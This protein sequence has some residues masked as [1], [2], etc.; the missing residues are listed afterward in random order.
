MSKRSA[1]IRADADEVATPGGGRD[2]DVSLRREIAALRESQLAWAARPVSAR[3]KI[4]REIRR[5]IA[6]DPETLAATVRLPQRASAAET[7]AAE[8]LPLA[9]ACRFLEREAAKAL[10]PRQLGRRGRALWLGRV[11]LRVLREPFGVVLVIAPWNY[12]LFLPGVQVLQALVA[13]NAVLLKPAPGASEPASAFARLCHSAGIDAGLFRVLPEPPEMARAAIA[14][15]VDKVILTGS[16]ATGQTVLAELAARL[17]PATMELSGCDAVFVRADADVELVAKALAFGLRLNG[18]ATCIAPRRVFV[19]R[20]LFD[21]LQQRLARLAAQMPAVPVAPET[22][23]RVRSLVGEALEA[24]AG[25]VAG[26]LNGPND[27]TPLVV[28]NAAPAMELLK[29]DVFAPVVSLVPVDSDEE[30]LAAAAQC[31]YALGAAVFGEA[32]GAAALAEKVDAGCVV[33]NDVIVPTADPRLPFGGRRR[34]GFGVTRGL[35]GLIEMT[36]I[37]AIAVRRGRWLPHL[38]PPRPDD[39]RL[40]RG[41]LGMAHGGRW[42]RRLASAW[43]LLRLMFGRR[44]S[45]GTRDPQ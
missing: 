31:P 36:Q 38:E 12:P 42:G 39:A 16:A 41:Y 3:L 44:R 19:H 23:A 43:D 21:A 22:A 14:A 10:A 13:G 35:E 27:F 15:G 26:D 24:G 5:R 25:L 29:S 18:G 11:N 4:V 20:S 8:V 1:K 2:L 45:R 7:L 34:S 40:V 37:K 32:K 9:D 28:T 17:T 6:R 30:A 33:V